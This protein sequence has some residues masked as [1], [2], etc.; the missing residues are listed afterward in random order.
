MKNLEE[1]FD[2]KFTAL[3]LLADGEVVDWL[4]TGLKT[5]I[6]AEVERAMNAVIPEIEGSSDFGESV[7]EEFYNKRLLTNIEAYKKQL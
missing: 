3:Y 7:G 4:V 1:R 5:F 6:K 2:E